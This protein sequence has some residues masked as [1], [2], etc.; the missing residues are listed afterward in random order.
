MIFLAG[1]VIGIADEMYKS[2]EVSHKVR[3]GGDWDRDGDFN[4]ETFKDLW[5]FE[6]IKD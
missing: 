3:W 6:L 2:G 5:H 4:D 1:I